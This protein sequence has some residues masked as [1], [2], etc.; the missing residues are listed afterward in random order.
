M[1][2]ELFSEKQ[3]GDKIGRT[4]TKSIALNEEEFQAIEDTARREKTS[5]SALLRRGLVK[6]IQETK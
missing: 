5:V 2:R 4:L 6:V 1:K 3:K